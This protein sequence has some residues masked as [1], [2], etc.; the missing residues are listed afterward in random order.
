MGVMNEFLQELQKYEDKIQKQQDR[1][2]ELED[3]LDALNMRYLSQVS[4]W[5]SRYEEAQHLRDRIVYKE[6]GLCHEVNHEYLRKPDYKDSTIKSRL[7]YVTDE[8]A[9]KTWEFLKDYIRNVDVNGDE[10]LMIPV[11]RVLDAL[12]MINQDEITYSTM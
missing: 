5:K 2:E 3:E 11:S 9:K 10:H 6:R 12:S 7:P 1:I 8:K 4:L